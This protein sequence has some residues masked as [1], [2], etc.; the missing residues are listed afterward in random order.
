LKDANITKDEQDH[1]RKCKI[2]TIGSIPKLPFLL[3]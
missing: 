1:L 3:H 2:H